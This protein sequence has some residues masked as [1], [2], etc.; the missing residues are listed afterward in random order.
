MLPRSEFNPE[1]PNTALVKLPPT[2]SPYS[3]QITDAY[4]PSDQITMYAGS[5]LSIPMS[6]QDD[7]VDN[8]DSLVPL[9]TA[10]DYVIEGKP[11]I[12]SHLILHNRHHILTKDTNGEITMWD[13]TK[14]NVSSS[15]YSTVLPIVYLLVRSNQKLWKERFRRRRSRSQQS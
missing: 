9:R 7:D 5:V 3:S 6:Y 12:I 15:T 13:L 4:V 14:V 10:P 8:E 1:I 11:G 2:K